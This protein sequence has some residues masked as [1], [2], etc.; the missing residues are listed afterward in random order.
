MFGRIA[1]RYDLMNTVMTL[2]LDDGW[3]RR[4]ARAANPPPNGRVLDVGAG[5]ARLASALAKVM[6]NGHVW[7]VDLSFA[8]LWRGRRW[9]WGAEEAD[10]VLLLQADALALPFPDR[11]FDCVTSAFSV[12]NLPDLERAFREQ[13]RVTKAGGAVVCLEL[14]WPRNA[15]LDRLFGVYFG[16]VVP[17]LGQLVTGDA[18]A[19]AYLPA[20]VRAFPR[21]EALARIMAQAG[22]EHVCWRRLGFG[23]VTLHRGWVGARPA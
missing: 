19:Y 11:A 3:R 12:R 6:P 21:P 8:M 7:G 22:L 16:G 4:A 20:S 1:G 18:G 9:L 10:R 2:G 14:A 17:W 13:A 23:T 15:W 5:T